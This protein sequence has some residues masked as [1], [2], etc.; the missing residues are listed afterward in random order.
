[1]RASGLTEIL[2]AKAYGIKRGDDREL[3]QEY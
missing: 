1:M 2:K 3:L